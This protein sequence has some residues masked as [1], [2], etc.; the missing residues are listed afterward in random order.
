MIR[1]FLTFARLLA[2]V[3]YGGIIY[4]G[5]AMHPFSPGMFIGLFVAWFCVFGGLFKAPA[6]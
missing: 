2:L 5:F 4:A 6:I 1:A 3:A